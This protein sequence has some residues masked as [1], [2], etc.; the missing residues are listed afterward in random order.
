[1]YAQTRFR[2]AFI[3]LFLTIGIIPA[4]SVMA[5]NQALK[6]AHRTQPAE[7][8]EE[9]ILSFSAPAPAAVTT[10]GDITAT[11]HVES[12][13][14]PSTL[15]VMLGKTDIT[16]WFSPS[17]CSIAPCDLTAQLN[18]SVGIASGWNSMQATVKGKTG[19]A[20][21]ANSRFYFRS[22]SAPANSIAASRLVNAGSDAVST[23]GS[24]G[25]LA[26]LP[27]AISIKLDP[28]GFTLGSNEYVC[29]NSPDFTM[30]TVDRTT[31]AI[32]NQQCLFANQM[33]SMI[34]GYIPTLTK[35]DMVF[36]YSAS[37]VAL[38]QLNMTAIGG[39]DFTKPSAPTVSNYQIVGYG[40]ASAGEAYESYEDQ[41]L[42]QYHLADI[43]GS[44][45]DA[46]SSTPFYGYQPT[47][48]PAFAIQTANYYATITVGYPTTLPF[49]NTAPTNFTL[50]ANY[51]QAP[52]TTP[53]IDNYIY[54]Q[55]Q[56][57]VWKLA[58]N[59]Y[60][61]SLFD[62]KFYSTGTD[63]SEI[64]RLNN[65]LTVT[66]NGT[67]ILLVTEGTNPFGA[68][69][70]GTP[71]APFA[72]L[73]TQ[74]AYLG[75]SP[76]AFAQFAA[77]DTGSF[78]L[79]GVKGAVLGNDKM[80]SSTSES[81]Q[82]DTGNL[83]G[84]FKRNHQY[85]YV[86]YQASSLDTSTLPYGYT[87]D[88]LLEFALATQI[89]SAPVTAWP[90]MD[91]VGHQA[92]YAYLSNVIVGRRLFGSGTCT[93]STSWCNDVRAWYTG[94]EV[95]AFAG[96][97]LS[98]SSKYAYPG[99]TVAA[100]NGFTN[101]DFTDV[102]TQLQAE[103]I[104]L[105]NTLNYQ[106]WFNQ[107]TN[108]AL[109]NTGNAL[110]FAANEVNSSLITQ[111]AQITPNPLTLDADA[112]NFEGSV[113]S[114]VGAFVPGSSIVGNIFKAAATGISIYRDSNPATEDPT[115]V[116]VAD[117][118]VTTGNAASVA[119]S[120]YNLAVQTQVGNY[121]SGVY[122][123]WFKLQ[124]FG[125][126]TSEPSS[127]GWYIEDSGN[128]TA[129]NVSALITANARI[130][131]YNQLLPQYFQQGWVANVPYSAL[132]AANQSP[133][134]IA[135]DVLG[136]N[137]LDIGNPGGLNDYTWANLTS[138]TNSS[139]KDYTVLVTTES[140]ANNGPPNAQY[141]SWASSLGDTLLGP[142]TSSNGLG[143]LNLSHYTFYDSTARGNFYS[144]TIFYAQS[145]APN[146]YNN[147]DLNVVCGGSGV[148]VIR[149]SPTTTAI[150]PSAT[151]VSA[152]G[153]ITLAVTVQSSETGTSSPTGI[154]Y[155]TTNSTVLS[156][157]AL[158]AG[159][160]PAAT[161][162]IPGSALSPGVYTI[163]VTYPGDSNY[164]SSVATMQLQVAGSP[165]ATATVIN[166]PAASTAGQNVTLQATVTANGSTPAGSVNFQ[167]G[168]TSLGS[169]PLDS[170]G[171]A[172]LSLSTF[173][174]GSH[175]IVALFSPSDSTQYLTSQSQNATLIV[176]PVAPDMLLSLSTGNVAVPYGTPS[177][178]VSVT[179]TSLSTFSG[180]VTF[181]CVGLPFGMTCNF[182][183]S[184]TSLPA[185]G[186]ASS[187]FTIT[188]PSTAISAGI[189]YWKSSAGLLLFT[190]S[191][192]LAFRVS[193]GRRS[194]AGSVWMSAFFTI[195]A[196][197]LIGCGGNGSRNAST[198]THQTGNANILVTATSGT[199][200]KSIPLSINVQ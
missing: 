96:L 18:L 176:A 22:S 93:A 161:L 78:S 133:L 173:G 62:S 198:D 58:L 160:A 46:G 197:I 134:A 187:S 82:N 74:I 98:S 144:Y 113:I 2:T 152:D 172:N 97:D 104:Y 63:L 114:I 44:L 199:V 158:S 23:P 183:P 163:S 135:A 188:Q 75:I 24:S 166:I 110:T 116:R 190:L 30:F 119:A 40:Q 192:L 10:D 118:L 103:F 117:L 16:S 35:N 169:V 83:K 70:P 50:P 143:N 66:T 91:T 48:S 29:A 121:F 51:T 87:N 148:S 109:L 136:D 149:Q 4:K 168:T 65:D 21:I 182:N 41:S 125:I 73:C 195:S 54:S 15:R 111:Y 77:T 5:Q 181:A 108:G 85:R 90:M 17:K 194:V 84:L 95:K 193:R 154:V 64:D 67:V 56:F 69:H 105:N 100:A 179:V 175:S 127:N 33:Q 86:P 32:T 141:A 132:V 31:L 79:A 37:G 20:G 167:D 52:Y 60:D 3:T 12:S 88:D 156:K 59:P 185:S 7:S 38:G 189:V 200:T 165:N 36:L 170:T 53:V 68:L 157:M 80:Y 14:D 43:Q 27:H 124:T 49:G 178:A 128:A 159:A 8:V 120:N 129:S 140:I 72:S 42:P 147:T 81:G 142:P 92:A 55:Q 150:R 6:T 164:L 34:N 184:Q 153:R 115:V 174:V 186:T 106:S 1:M 146:P 94:N 112:L 130:S 196:V 107:V 89:S 131:F 47:D 39:T 61:L 145:W 123:D 19:N 101:S 177:S 122:A 9:P 180:Q 155:A 71:Y 138:P 99:D 191:T 28:S 26:V 139:C 25:A 126:L 151:T 11:L 162:S 137:F 45:V 171:K 13:A 76:H 102:A 57:G